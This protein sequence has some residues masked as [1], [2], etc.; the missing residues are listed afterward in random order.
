MEVAAQAWVARQR[1]WAEQAQDMAVQAMGLLGGQAEQ[2]MLP[3]GG[4]A[5]QARPSAGE[6]AAQ[7]WVQN[8]GVQGQRW[9]ILLR[10]GFACPG[11]P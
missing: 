7:A 11:R 4:P 2:A 10:C 9:P 1:Q 6:L 3:E 8:L 5:E